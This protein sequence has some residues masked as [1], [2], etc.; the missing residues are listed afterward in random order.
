M[1]KVLKLKN[2]FFYA[3]G[4]PL[5]L[6]SFLGGLMLHG[7]ESR[8]RT[9]FL[10]LISERAQ[11]VEKERIEI[12]EKN[13]KKNKKG[14]LIYLD[15]DGKETADKVLGTSFVFENPENFIKELTDYL[16]EEYLIDVSP[17]NSETV[18]TVKGIVLNTSKE[19]V[20]GEANLY[21]DWCDAFENIKEE[22][23]K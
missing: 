6:Q 8:E 10:K 13:C 23:K 1:S 20:G 3:G 9:R 16:N 2:Y 18:N 19:F 14:E 12:G 4:Q 21:N 11:E 17:A 5:T 7:K 22:E 15:K